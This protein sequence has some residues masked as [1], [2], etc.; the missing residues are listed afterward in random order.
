M[1]IKKNI[2][3]ILFWGFLI[4]LCLFILYF[5][6]MKLGQK[7][8][9]ISIKEFF[10]FYIENVMNIK[11]SFEEQV[12]LEIVVS[13]YNE[14]L[15]WLK[16]E[17][18]SDYP[19]I[20]YNKGP[21]DDFYKAPNITK[22][23]SLE[24][25]GRC[26]H[27]YL[28]HIIQNYDQLSDIT[29]FLPGSVEM[30]NKYSKS[31]MTILEGAKHNNTIILKEHGTLYSP[32]GVKNDLYNFTLDEWKSSDDRN[33]LLNTEYKLLPATTRPFG[34]WYEEHFPY[35]NIEYA[36]FLGILC[37][38]KKHIL[39]H[40]KSYYENLIQELNTHSNPEVG[41][42]FERSWMAVFHP[43]DDASIV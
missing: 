14:N 33:R 41:H 20:V 42:Y 25:V 32:N 21:N 16:E 40:P 5:Y 22:T 3:N 8:E 43:L 13:R 1:K 7:T 31:R 35:V 39:Q 34:K 15:E 2:L 19:V 17:P 30:E 37:I 18:F 12:N 28:Y 24:N 36:T 4:L 29:V 9:M 23:V 6:L 38:H 11:E 10:T 27:T 26:D